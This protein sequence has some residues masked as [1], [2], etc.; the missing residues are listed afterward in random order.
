[1]LEALKDSRVRYMDYFGGDYDHVAHLTNDPVSQLHQVEDLDAFVGR[2]WRAIEASP[3]AATTALV[4]VS[5]HGMA[6]SGDV[7]SQGYNLVDWF[8]SATGGAHHVLTNRHPLSEFKMKGLDPFVSAVVT[9]S[10]QSAYLRDQGADYPT[11]MLDLDGNERASIGLRNNTFNIA[12]ILLQ[13]I[14]R[15][16]LAP[17][18][19]IAAIHALMEELDRVRGEWSRDLEAMDQELARL[20]VQI[21]D[22]RTAVE[23]QPKKWTPEQVENQLHRDANR[24]G[25]QLALYEED[26]SS[27]AA[28]AAIIR[29]L[30]ALTPASFDPGKFKRGELIPVRSLGPLNSIWDLR[31]Y[32]TGVA[33]GGLV[34]GAD[35]RLD[36]GRSFT[37]VDYLMALRAIRV[38]N[39]VQAQV[40]PRPVDFIALDTKDGIWLYQDEEHQALIEERDGQ[41]R[42]RPVAHLAADRDGALRYETPELSAGFPLAYFE[43]P[44]FTAGPV[45]LSEWHTEQEWFGAVHR[46]RYSNGIIGIVEQMRESTRGDDL[47]RRKRHLRR[48]DLLVFAADHWNF[49]VRGFNPGGN[50]GSFLRESTHSVLMFAGGE[51]TG[52]PRGARVATPY[53]SLSFVP[54]VLALMGRAEAGLPGPV[55]REV[56]PQDKLGP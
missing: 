20:D 1:M 45:W 46:A 5:D 41:I 27:Y 31:N 15:K 53:D 3:M 23:A 16:G 10:K 8:N 14:A 9:P 50:H 52:I 25:R 24:R 34:L 4:L 55:I 33:P 40:G 51:R 49:N 42:Y 7:F 44:Y 21:R 32:V 47:D 12:Q 29:R 28:Y 56:M 38:K 13:E 18:K 17:A 6:T 26:R 39:N 2:V 36:F 19:R 11:V 54:T 22:L 35:G 48:T 43:D 30:L 37:R